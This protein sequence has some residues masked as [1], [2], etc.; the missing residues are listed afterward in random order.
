MF[1]KHL[2]VMPDQIF[3]SKDEVLDFLTHLENERVSDP[4]GYGKDVK[5]REATFATYIFEGIA[6]PHAKS[7][8]VKEPFVVYAKLREAVHWGDDE[9]EDANQVFLLGVPKTNNGNDSSNLHLQI[10]TSLSKKLVH[11]DFRNSLKD[12]SSTD[13]IYDLLKKFEEEMNV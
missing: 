9:G 6:I 13:E 8:N 11:E 10:L 1:E 12:A 7:D 3:Q 4:D 5:E 2:I